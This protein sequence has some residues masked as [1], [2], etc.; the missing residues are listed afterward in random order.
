MT[1]IG[2]P[3]GVLEKHGARRLALAMS[4]DFARAGASQWPSGIRDIV[5]PALDDDLR[6]ELSRSGW[7]AHA[8][9]SAPAGIDGV[10][11]IDGANFRALMRRLEPLARRDCLILPADPD[12]VVPKA[13]RDGDAQYGAWQTSAAA[14]YVARCNLNGHY[15]EF[16]TFW[17]SSFFPNYFRFRHWL[18]G[19]FY[20][21]D[22]FRGLS[23]PDADETRFTGGDFAEG[24]YCA[25][26]RSFAALA[27]MLQVPRERLA[28]IPGFYDRT[29]AGVDPARYGLAPHSLSVCYIDCDLREPTAQV[30]DFVTPLVETGGLIY[31]DDW[32]LCR[33][34]RVVGERAAALAWLARNPSIELIELD[35]DHWQNQWFILQ[36]RSLA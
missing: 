34:S 26:T 15:A 8:L 12:W 16:G 19:S 21:F 18:A 4:A 2:L 3:V 27:D 23:T 20:A 29:L 17:G 33:A 1:D 6:Q 11:I 28:I 13:L 10:V 30:L 32:R 9:Y 35:R 22:S 5:I 31:F 36:R 14:N 7:Q 25:N 24:A